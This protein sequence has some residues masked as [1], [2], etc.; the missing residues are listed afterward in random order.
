MAPA[1]NNDIKSATHG[2]ALRRTTPQVKYVSRETLGW[3]A[4]SLANA[5]GTE[6]R[7]EQGLYART[8][9]Q[10]VHLA[11]RE[12]QAFSADQKIIAANGLVQMR[13]NL[14]QDRPMAGV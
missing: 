8:T 9:R 11:A 7:V 10:C 4:P 5:K 12:A 2:L 1:H 3:P 14:R 6:Q 13:L